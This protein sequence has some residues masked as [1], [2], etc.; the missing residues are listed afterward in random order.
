MVKQ[1]ISEMKNGKVAI[2]PGVVSEMVKAA[3]EA[4]VG[5]TIDLVN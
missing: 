5:V 1:S 4:R 3:V 2:L